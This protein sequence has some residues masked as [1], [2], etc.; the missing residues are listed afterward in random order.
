VKGILIKMGSTR[1][2]IIKR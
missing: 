2:S 1:S